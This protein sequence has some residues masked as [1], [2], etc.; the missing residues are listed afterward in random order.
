MDERT[1]PTGWV[2]PMCGQGAATCEHGRAV[3]EQVI[4]SYKAG[5]LVM[6]PQV[7]HAALL[8]N[9]LGAVLG[10]AGRDSI[11]DVQEATVEACRH[12]YAMRDALSPFPRKPTVTEYLPASLR[13]ACGELV[14]ESKPTKARALSCRQVDVTLEGKPLD[15]RKVVL[16][17][18]HDALVTAT[19]E[20]LPSRREEA[21]PSVEVPRSG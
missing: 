9:L 5:D 18:A 11:G 17:I 12:A 19:V 3:R 16:T 10:D 2:C 6:L 1:A 21:S 4:A 13:V 15:F 14:I 7:D 20:F 8:W